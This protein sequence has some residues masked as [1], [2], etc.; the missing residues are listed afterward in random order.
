MKKDSMKVAKSIEGS[1][2]GLPQIIFD[3]KEPV[4]EDLP[5]RLQFDRDTEGFLIVRG[6]LTETFSAKDVQFSFIRAEGKLTSYENNKFSYDAEGEESIQSVVLVQTPEGMSLCT[7]LLRKAQ[8]EI[9]YAFEKALNTLNEMLEKNNRTD[10]LGV[11][12]LLLSV[13]CSLE[14]KKGLKGS[15]LVCKDI[16]MHQS[17][18]NEMKDRIAFIHENPFS[19]NDTMS[20][21][22]DY[23]EV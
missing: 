21:L 5:P 10:L 2:V 11:G 12:Y 1:L 8:C 18:E 7:A 23:L 16:Q 13:S 19:V 20:I 14:S 17:T 6:K 22:T 15:Y 4:R 9:F 3:V